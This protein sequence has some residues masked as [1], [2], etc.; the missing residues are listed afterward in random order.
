MSEFRYIGQCAP[1]FGG[2]GQRLA[3]TAV[4]DQGG[5]KW[6]TCPGCSKRAVLK[7]VEGTYNPDHK[8]D[9]RCTSAKGHVCSCSCGGANHGADWGIQEV[10]I[11][12]GGH[13]APVNGGHLGEVGKHI[14]GM[15]TVRAI[16]KRSP[17]WLV[18]LVTD[19]NDVIKWWVPEAYAPEDW[20]EGERFKLRAKVIR[21]ED[22]EKFGKSTVVI[23]AE[24]QEG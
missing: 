15:V 21:H 8:C 14:T 5:D 19:S 12:T 23:Y 24:R 7:L 2:C 13:K 4:T 10:T 3:V 18:T 1:K 20:A 22:H 6:V 9:V 16:L 17:K 11:V